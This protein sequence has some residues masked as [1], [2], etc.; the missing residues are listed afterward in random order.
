MKPEWKVQLV[1]DMYRHDISRQELADEAG[2][3]VSYINLLLADKRK[4][5]KS[6]PELLEAIGRIKEKKE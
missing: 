1:A 4:G 2:V 5:E 3:T 6:K